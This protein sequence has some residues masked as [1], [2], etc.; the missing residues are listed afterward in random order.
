MKSI[1]LKKIIKL[2]ANKFIKKNQIFLKSINISNKPK[3]QKN[4]YKIY[5]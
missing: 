2:Y 1:N 3:N 5:L 4:I